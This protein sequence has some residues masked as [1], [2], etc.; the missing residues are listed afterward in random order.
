M[1]TEYGRRGQDEREGPHKEGDL[2]QHRKAFVRSIYI[3]GT[4]IWSEDVRKEAPVSLT[5]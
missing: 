2:C 5:D 3:R 1:Y 4:E